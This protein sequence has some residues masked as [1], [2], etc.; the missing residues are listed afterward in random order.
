MIVARSPNSRRLVD[1]WHGGDGVSTLAIQCARGEVAVVCAEWNVAALLWPG[2]SQWENP[3]PAAP[4]AVYFVRTDPVEISFAVSADV[5]L[6][7]RARVSW[8]AQGA[9][10]VYCPDAEAFVAQFV[11]LPLEDVGAGV[12]RSLVSSFERL[13][14]RTLTR[15]VFG[16]EEAQ[17]DLFADINIFAAELARM[18]LTAGAVF[19]L[20]V[21]RL[22]GLDVFPT[23]PSSDPAGARTSEMR[24]LKSPEVER[25]THGFQ[26]GQSVMVV[27]HDGRMIAA[28]I[29]ELVE[30]YAEVEVG[31]TGERAWVLRSQLIPQ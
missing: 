22:V 14:A 24:A 28:T 6:P 27:W 2:V 18:G 10:A 29:V 19:G 17:P 12:E 23:P 31:G 25:P 26:A 1:V 30:S 9:V 5:R 15:F 20:E 3:N 13:A 11:G 7:S 8:T 4:V 21:E 16:A